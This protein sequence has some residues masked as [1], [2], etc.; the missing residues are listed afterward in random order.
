MT[1]INYRIEPVDLAG[2]LF[3]VTM[4]IPEPLRDGQCVRLPA[5]IPGSY[6]IRDFARNIVTLTAEAGGKPV[7]VEKL[8]KQ[9]WR[10]GR[11]P[12]GEPLVLRYAVYAWDLS[13]RAAHLDQTHGFFNGTSV[14]L[15]ADGH[16][17]QPCLVDIRPPRSGAIG[18]W[19][20]ATA[21]REAKGR[22]GAAKRHG[23]GLYRADNYDELIDHPVEMG[24]F[25]LASFKAGGI[26]HEVVLTGRHDCDTERLCADLARICQ[27]QID[28]F[29]GTP[30][31]DRYV[32]LTLVVGDGYGGLEHRASTALL[33]SRNELPWA[34]MEGTPEAYQRFLGLCSHEYFHSWNVKRIKPA[35][36]TPYELAAESYTRL[37]WAFEG[38]TSYY[39]DLCLVR[40]GVVTP[41]A[42]LKSLGE[43]I[44]RVERGSGRLKQS[45]ADSSFDAWSKFYKQDENAPNAIVSYYTK[46]SLIALALDLK[47]REASGGDF[48]LDDVMRTLWSRHG[49]TGLGVPEAGVFEIVAQ[50][51]GDA[52]ARWLKRAVNG[53]DDLPLAKLLKP[54]GVS[55]TTTAGPRPSLGVR[56]KSKTGK[57]ILAAVHEGSAAHLAG[58]SAGDT[59]VAIDGLRVT[60]E[61]LDGML[62][63]KAAG[64]TLQVHFFRRDE[65]M[66]VDLVLAA[67][68]V[69]TQLSL[70]ARP[71]AKTRRLRGGWLGV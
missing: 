15:S 49:E 6:M 48:S 12:V 47:L 60:A 43:T 50:I 62:E 45:V 38:F 18:V 23:F 64:A 39:D 59:L 65:L 44:T 4:E 28:L 42:Y 68:E 20:V 67:G 13:V 24:A 32:F 30:P 7:A 1:A 27:W 11:V 2:H 17:A 33:T 25:T 56:L 26:P 66:C 69:A 55:L 16:E 19:R 54:V 52:I 37:L 41:E 10:C 57:A 36:F 9:T 5:W 53:T 3:E 46:G 35:R 71:D 63:R 22:A 14:F 8:D 58:L 40:S 70:V 61:T 51:G 34:G 21:M 29:G 31:M